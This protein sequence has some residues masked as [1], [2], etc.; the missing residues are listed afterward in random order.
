LIRRNIQEASTVTTNTLR[1]SVV[2]AVDKVCTLYSLNHEQLRRETR[3]R[4]CPWS[5][6]FCV[7]QQQRNEA[8]IKPKEALVL[9]EKDLSTAIDPLEVLV[10]QGDGRARII[11]TGVIDRLH[12][13]RQMFERR[14]AVTRYEAWRACRSTHP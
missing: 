4:D 11:A 2:N 7:Q 1:F 6:M 9:P 3:A 12:A 5:S 14:V 8:I 13:P 10:S